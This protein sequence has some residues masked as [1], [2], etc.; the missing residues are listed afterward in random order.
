MTL[1]AQYNKLSARLHV[2]PP[3]EKQKLQKAFNKLYWKLQKRK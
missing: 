1:Q 3:E 2:C